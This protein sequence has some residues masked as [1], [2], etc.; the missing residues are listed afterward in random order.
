MKIFVPVIRITAV[1]RRL[2]AA[3]HDAQIGAR[4]RFGQRH[5]A[6]PFAGIQLRQIQRLL[7]LAAVVGDTRSC[8][9]RQRAAQIQAGVRAVEHFFER[10]RQH[11]RQ[12]LAAVGRITGHAE[13][14][15]VGQRAETFFETGRRLHAFGAP[16][17]ARAVADLVERSELFGCDFAALLEHG[18]NEIAGHLGERR[19]AAP[20]RFGVEQVEQHEFHVARRG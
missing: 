15:A 20:R 17:R 6:G 9:D 3:A 12:T 10:D 18:C 2:R 19:N 16:R 1:G 5:C 14:A 7:R 13:P 8:A 4:V 11:L